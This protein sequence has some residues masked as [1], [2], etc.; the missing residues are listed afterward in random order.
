M[1]EKER[2]KQYENDKKSKNADKGPLANL[3]IIV[4]IGI[5][6][7]MKEQSTDGKKTKYA[8]GS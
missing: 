4:V 2:T 6:M 7:I 3:A 5:R 8:S 1:I